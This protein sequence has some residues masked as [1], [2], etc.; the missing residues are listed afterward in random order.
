MGWNVLEVG[1][2][3]SC[4]AVELSSVPLSTLVIVCVGAGACGHYQYLQ[5]LSILTFETES[6]LAAQD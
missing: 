1:A 5:L 4:M 3:D 2:G 6:E